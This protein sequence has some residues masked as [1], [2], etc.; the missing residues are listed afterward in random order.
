[1]LTYFLVISFALFGGLCHF[2]AAEPQHYNAA[3]FYYTVS[4]LFI[5]A[6]HFRSKWK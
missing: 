3:A 4:L 2:F 5:I 1:M 6:D